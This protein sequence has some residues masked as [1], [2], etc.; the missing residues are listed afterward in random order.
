MGTL[1][2]G[3]QGS[4]ESTADIHVAIFPVDAGTVYVNLPADMRAGERAS[5]TVNPVPGGAANDHG[6]NRRALER[7]GVAFGGQAEPVSQS[8]R[9]F[10]IPSDAAALDVTLLDPRGEPVAQVQVPLDS[11]AT[12]ADSYRVPPVG[13][14]GSPVRI[15]GPFD[16]DLTNSSVQIDG[17]EATPMAESQRQLV[18]R[19]P[20]EGVSSAQVEV[21]D[22][23]T[24]V[25]TGTYRNVSVGLAAGSTRLRSGETT[26]LT[27]TVTGVEGLRETLPVRLTN[28]SPDV[29][30]MERGDQQTLCVRPDDVNTGGAWTAK[31][32]LTGVKLGGFSLSTQVSQPRPHGESRVAI[33]GAVQ[34]EL[35]GGVMLPQRVRAKGGQPLEAGSYAVTVRGAGQGGAV[36]LHL[37][38]EGQL[39]GT[40]PGVVLKRVETATVCDRED[41]TD[42][43]DQAR[44]GSGEPAF[45]DL[46]FVNG[47]LF[48]L[49]GQGEGLHVELRTEEEDFAIQAGLTPTDSGR[50]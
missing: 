47:A 14:S 2:E 28:H 8:V 10:T 32:Q 15:E 4:L 21:E 26:T 48:A 19:G 25:T 34:G 36:T 45:S 13:Q 12:T 38:R 40:L 50:N 31:R 29:V 27:V 39:M 35:H 41:V 16:G 30:R 20:Q 5:G 44:S 37:G 6:K 24:N 3:A 33:S 23:G 43:V 22:R 7:Y 49:G 11:A 9:P 1:A 18:V 42:A 17:Q 46:G